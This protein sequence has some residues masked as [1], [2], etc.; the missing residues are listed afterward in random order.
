[1]ADKA[2]RSN[3]ALSDYVGIALNSDDRWN[4]DDKNNVDLPIGTTDLASGQNDY[5]LD[6]TVLKVIKVE[7][8][9]EEGKWTELQPIDRNDT[10][11]PYDELFSTGTPKY[12]DK[13]ANS[14]FL[15]PT[16]DY[17]ADESLR[18]WFQRDASYFTASDTTKQPGIPSIFHK[19]IALKVSEPYLRDNKKENYVS[20]RNEIQKYEEER[21]PEFYAKR[22]KDERPIISGA[23]IDCI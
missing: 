19:Y 23:R 8:K 3:S 12:Y 18:V 2:R 21:I 4:F 22:N 17:D 6:S 13:F 20:V 1:L 16:P 15:F 5:S 11:I 9:D 7:L 14:A 10:N